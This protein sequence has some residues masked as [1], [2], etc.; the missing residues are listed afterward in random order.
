M[1]TFNPRELGAILGFNHQQHEEV[2]KET[3]IILRSPRAATRDVFQGG[4]AV[5][6]A[7]ETPPVEISIQVEA[8]SKSEIKALANEAD[9]VAI[10]RSMPMKLIEPI[11]EDGQAQP[12]AGTP[13]WGVN[14]VGAVTSPFSGDGVVVSVLDTGIDP[15][16]PAFAGVALIQ[17]NFT[18]AGPNDEHGHGTHCAGTI[19]GRDVG[20]TRIGVA[21]GVK[22]ALIGKVL[23]PG[24]GS[25]DQIADAISWAIENGAH[26]I[27][28]S[29][30][31]DFPG[32]VKILENNGFPTEAAV[33]QALEGYRA[34]VMLFERLASLIKARGLFGQTTLVVA[35]AGNESRRNA[36]PPYEI[37]VAPPAVADGVISVA[38]LGESAAG[39]T[40]A[41][42]SNTFANVS[43]PGVGVVSAKLGG[44]LVGMSG[45]SMATPHVAGVA[46]LWAEKIMK[47]GP[48]TGVEWMARLIGSTTRSGL[49]SGFDPADIGAGLVRAPQP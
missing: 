31:I 49:A 17:K 41:P 10:A 15:N 9:V 14:A 36:T 6:G 34:N 38:A 16:H 45:T 1:F 3:H 19:F 11:S 35:A 21:P 25:S 22:K 20:G 44:S 30:G 4:A 29:L 7:L 26:V 8:V 43:G 28:M 47:A 12:A 23:G 40:V 39:L 42:F 48:L 32:F 37:A 33:T 2:M 13:T 18:T 27:S 5:F 46:A 24:G